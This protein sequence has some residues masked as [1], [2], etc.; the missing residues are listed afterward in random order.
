M[1]GPKKNFNLIYILE[2]KG[3]GFGRIT[4]EVI[5]CRLKY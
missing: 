4:P 2:K 3:K 1:N 5:L